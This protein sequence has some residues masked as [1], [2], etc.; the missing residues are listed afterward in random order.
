MEMPTAFS[1]LAWRIEGGGTISLDVHRKLDPF[2]PPSDSFAGYGTLKADAFLDS[3]SAAPRYG[4]EMDL[5]IAMTKPGLGAV[6]L[7]ASGRFDFSGQG[8]AV[9]NF[10][11]FRGVIPSGSSV[12]VSVTN[13]EIMWHAR[14][15]E[16]D[17]SESIV[18]KNIE[19]G[20][21]VDLLWGGGPVLGASLPGPE[22]S[23]IAGGI[24]LSF[25]TS[26]IGLAPFD[27]SVFV[28]VGSGWTP[29]LGIRVGRL[30]S[31]D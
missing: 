13:A 12:F 19:L 17:A 8:L 3:S 15:L 1:S 31:V 29:V 2:V 9:E 20:P 10:D 18:V 21:Y 22:P 5:R 14:I 26:L 16:F 11:D 28:G 27:A 24:A 7:R 30:F 23:S 4:P 25:T 6:H